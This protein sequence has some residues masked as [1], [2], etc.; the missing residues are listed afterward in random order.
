MWKLKFPKFGDY[1]TACE[2]IEVTA[3]G[4]P[5]HIGSPTPGMGYENGDPYAE[6]LPPAVET[7]E[8]GE[9]EYMR[10]VVIITENTKK[11]TAR[12][13][14]EYFDP[15]L[16]LEGEEYENL[17]F[18][19]LHRRI[20]DTLRGDKPAVTMESISPEGDVTIYYEDGTSRSVPGDK[21]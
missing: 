6:F 15:L 21:S 1:H 11:G 18:S 19:E 14:Q 12:N 13:G 5:P 4:V 20:C 10:A 2:W 7:N 3:Q 8:D 16:T 9:A 17:P